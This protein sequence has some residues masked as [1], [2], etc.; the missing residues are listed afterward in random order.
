MPKLDFDYEPSEEVVA[1]MDSIHTTNFAFYN[2][3]AAH[4][5]SS[6]ALIHHY[7]PTMD[8]ET[9]ARAKQTLKLLR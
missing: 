1:I 8:K 5:I 6:K 7:L 2:S 9:K 4:R 3:Q